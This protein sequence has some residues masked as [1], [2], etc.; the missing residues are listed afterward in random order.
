[1]FSCFMETMSKNFLQDSHFHVCISYHT[2]LK[3][4]PG[5]IKTENISIKS[6][7]IIKV[8]LAM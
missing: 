3:Q 1:M 2:L 8:F 6:Y 5:T 7:R 4:T